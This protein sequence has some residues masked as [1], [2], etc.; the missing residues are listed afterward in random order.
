MRRRLVHEAPLL[1]LASIVIALSFLIPTLK[2]HHAWLNV[3]CVFHAVTG[4][5]CL[6][7]GLTRSFVFT[8]HGAFAHAFEMH[9]LGPILFV[10]TC[11]AAAYMGTSLVTGYGV[12]YSLS[13]RARRIAFWS[14]LGIF[15]ACW[16]IKLAFI[17]SG[18]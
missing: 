8:A 4:L 1:V 9:L 15:L 10:A 14:T 18:W 16:G 17:R 3:P 2:S 6:A 13:T 7:C 11:A 5:P 12:R